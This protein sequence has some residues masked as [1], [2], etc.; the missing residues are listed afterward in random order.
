MDTKDI[1][2]KV[3]TVQELLTLKFG[4]KRQPLAKM[5]ARAGRRLPKR[6]QGKVGTL[7]NAEHLV[8]H[9]RLA[10]QMDNA[11]VARAYED[12][13]THLKKID[14]ADRRLGK[15]LGLAGVVAFNLL[16]VVAGFVLWMWWRG[17]V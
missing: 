4:I 10:R 9:P 3:E 1:A 5:L 2:R 11:A 7:I 13:T 15:M 6:M 12:V 8:G 14:V 16:L 17:Y